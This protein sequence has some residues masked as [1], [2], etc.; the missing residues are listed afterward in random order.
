MAQNTYAPGFVPLDQQ[1]GV[2]ID[3]PV[4]YDATYVDEDFLQHRHVKGF[5]VDAGG[6]WLVAFL[7]AAVAF[8]PAATTSAITAP[9]PPARY[10]PTPMNSAVIAAIRSA[11]LT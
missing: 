3:D 6:D 4:D 10:Q 11:V 1:D 5:E 8:I 2:R 9:P 7:V